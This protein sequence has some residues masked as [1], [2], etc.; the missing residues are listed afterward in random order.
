MLPSVTIRRAATCDTFRIT[1]INE[2]APGDLRLL[3]ALC[4]Y[5]NR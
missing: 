5:A 4:R 1:S 2:M 3:M